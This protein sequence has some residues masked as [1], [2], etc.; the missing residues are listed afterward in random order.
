MNSSCKHIPTNTHGYG[1]IVDSLNSKSDQPWFGNHFTPTARNGSVDWAEFVGAESHNISPGR[2]E[3]SWVNRLG[4]ALLADC[5]NSSPRGSH[6]EP[7]QSYAAVAQRERGSAAESRATGSSVG[8]SGQSQW[9]TNRRQRSSALRQEA[10]NHVSRST[11]EN[12][13]SATGALGG[14]ESS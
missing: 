14:V 8:G 7:G 5:Y 13:R 3:I 4:T 2:T 6:G 11:R 9:I 12:R 10:E 1:G